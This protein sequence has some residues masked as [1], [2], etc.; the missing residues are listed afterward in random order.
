NDNDHIVDN[1]TDDED[2]AIGIYQATV[3]AE[4]DGPNNVGNLGIFYYAIDS[5]GSD[6]AHLF[7]N[8]ISTDYS[9]SG[10]ITPQ[11]A[12][13]I[14]GM[15][16][17][18]SEIQWM[19]MT[20]DSGNYQN[21]VPDSGNYHIMTFD[22][23]GLTEGMFPDTTYS[24]VYVDDHLTGYDFNYVTPT[25][26][27]EGYVT[28]ENRT[29]IAD[30]EVRAG[31]E[32]AGNVGATTDEFGYYQ[33]GVIEGN[34]KVGLRPDELIPGYLIPNEEYLFVADGSTESV[35]FIAFTANAA[36]TGLV[37]LDDVP[38]E[39]FL[40]NA[41]SQVGWTE[42]YSGIDGS[43]TL[44]VSS[45]ADNFEGY[46]IEVR[47]FP[48][49]IY[50]NEHY[51]N[52]LSGTSNI[53]FHLYY[54]DG[55]VEGYLYDSETFE[56]LHNGWISATQDYENWFNAGVENN[57]Y[58]YL[59]LPNGTFDIMAYSDNYLPGLAESIVVSDNNVEH[60][61]YLDPF[62]F[63][64][65]VYGYVYD[66]GSGNPLEGVDVWVNSDVY[67]DGAVTDNEGF[68]YISLPNG[69]YSIDAWKEGYMGYHAGGIEVFDEEVQHDIILTPQG[70]TGSLYGYV[71]EANTSDP[72]Y[73]AIVFIS[74]EFFN[75][76]VFSNME[77]FY[78][79]D[80]LNGIYT[81]DVTKEGF[82]TEFIYDV[83]IDND[84]VFLN[85]FLT[86]EIGVDDVEQISINQ[87][88]Q[89]SPNPFKD[90]TTISFSLKEN[91]D[92]QI[93]IYNIRGQ[94]VKT[95]IDAK[96]DRGFYNIVWDGKDNDNRPVSAG[97][98]LYKFRSSEYTSS[99][100]MIIIR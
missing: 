9:V 59:S 18:D 10:N 1:A 74:N 7:I 96:K 34:W 44:S 54:A 33:L 81:V 64:G 53:D 76:G 20:D 46:N 57:G 56:P 88:H 89:N 72:V 69:T 79:A 73:N 78:E 41:G 65:A 55:S 6:F 17:V 97:V 14:V 26:F 67:W 93:D 82:E 87:L 24:D 5:G 15:I 94:F 60:D 29:A 63:D 4:D 99:R 43:Y 68:F 25:S 90:Q 71:Y 21:F 3:Y 45:V 98:Y 58:Y 37:Y 84:D 91:S 40:V 95:L 80:L 42:T 50:V 16:P 100:K 28:D 77:G 66:F 23:L 19:V 62:S 85:V 2:P 61:F 8:A 38:A 12:N 39:G 36:I 92:V 52:V 11:M 75:V 49:G 86:P 31:S 51:D 48:L 83:V 35:D 32:N 30:V 22:P 47:D 13:L 27:I 70:F